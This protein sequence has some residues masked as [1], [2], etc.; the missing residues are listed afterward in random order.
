[1][2]IGSPALARLKNTLMPYIGELY[3][4]CKSHIGNLTSGYWSIG[5]GWEQG[6]WFHYEV[7]KVTSVAQKAAMQA[8][9]IHPR[10]ELQTQVGHI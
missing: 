1:M 6:V 2:M 7:L 5:R 9:I 4:E 3:T 8:L 10:P